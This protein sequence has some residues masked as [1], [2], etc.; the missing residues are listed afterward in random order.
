LL[1]L[2]PSGVV[3]VWPPSGLVLGALVLVDR[4]LWPVI[5]AGSTFGN[6]AA[7]LQ[8][9]AGIGLAFVGATINAF[10]QALAATVVLR[11]SGPQMHFATLRDVG[12][13]VLG[14]AVISNSFTA[15]L[16]AFVL[17]GYSQLSFWRGWVN[18]WAGDGMGMLVLAPVV[19]ALTHA[20]RTRQRPSAATIAEGALVV[21]AV[22]TVAAFLLFG[23]GDSLS[24]LTSHAYIVFPLL[25]WAGFRLGA[26]GAAISMLALTGVVAW[27]AVNGA[28]TLG[29]GPSELLG[30]YTYLSLASLSSLVPAAI[31]SERAAAGRS[32]VESEGR[33]REIADFIDEAFFVADVTERKT[34][35]VN[36]GW[37][38][39]WGRPILDGYDPHIWF[40]S[41]HPDDRAAMSAAMQANA[42]GE[43]TT[44]VFRITRPDGEVRWLRGRAFPVKDEHGIVRRVAGVTADITELRHVEQRYIQAQ[45]LEAVGRLASGVAHDFNNLLTVIIGEAGSFADSALTRESRDSLS[46][47]KD[48]ADRAAGLTR[49]LLSF[50]RRQIIE[51]RVFDLNVAVSDTSKMLRRLIG[52]HIGLDI[53]LA[54]QALGVLAD[55]GQIEQIITNLAVNSRDAMPDGGT[56]IVTTEATNDEQ[57]AFATDEGSQPPAMGWVALTVTDTGVGM[58][59]EVLAHAFEPFFSTKGRTQGTGLGLATCYGIATQAGGRISISSTPGKG[60]SVRTLLPRVPVARSTTEPS[61]LPV[62]PHGTEHILL[63]EDDAAVRAITARLL[64]AQGYRV[65]E[66]RDATSALHE[67]SRAVKPLHLLLT[68]VVLPGVGGRELAD[69]VTATRPEIK[70]LFVTGY[71]DD[72]VLK[73]KWSSDELA[74]LQ[75]P[76]TSDQLGRRVRDVLDRKS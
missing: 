73:G 36:K 22:V 15:L 14:A 27:F 75:K 37:A 33:F 41:I 47:I 30:I 58:S 46:A 8:H 11:L 57:L 10:E 6:A 62:Q 63:V 28:L 59:H 66:A 53:R 54:Q 21:A 18:W 32:L 50:S 12:A 60:T 26:P 76:F 34:L 61:S 9:G 17:Q 51:P 7:D 25:M 16:G 24:G 1:V 13:L 72:V 2:R 43:P 23:G 29:T 71:T 4:R 19:L 20:V 5:L 38:T 65:V 68:D 39:I 44:S 35:Y 40:N 42:Q 48:A 69:I 56:L 55:R 31:L 3:F 67:L 70:V 64:T 45:K 74:V 49:Q 52:E